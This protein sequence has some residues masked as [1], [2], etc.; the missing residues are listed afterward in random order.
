MDTQDEELLDLLVSMADSQNNEVD[1]SQKEGVDHSDDEIV[2]G[3]G[4]IN[5]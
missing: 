5:F 2:P 4:I 3:S 1:G